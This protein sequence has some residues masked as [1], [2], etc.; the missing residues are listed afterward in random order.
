MGSRLAMA[1]DVT[2][3]GHAP[4][5]F[6]AALHTYFAVSDIRH[7]SV[8]GLEGTEYLDKVR[9]FE[10]TRE[11]QGAIRFAGETDRVYLDTEA[12]CVIHDPGLARRIEVA[13][14]GSRTT[15][16]WNP[17]IDRAK[18]IADF[19]DDEWPGMLCIETA[20]VRDA[21]VEVQPG[22]HHTMTAS[23]RVAPR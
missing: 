2:N 11:G 9:N 20:N 10:R 17:W 8:T 1:L 12:T 6:E 7:A 14:T 4:A 16:V 23:I 5:R 21:A 15:V 13:K 18:A 3:T 22:S 19:G